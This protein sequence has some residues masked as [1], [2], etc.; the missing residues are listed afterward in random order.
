MKNLLKALLLALF[1]AAFG[2]TE[3]YA[4]EQAGNDP[5]TIV[6]YADYQCP[7]CGYYHNFVQK[8][9][10]E[11]GDKI[12]VE[13]RFFPLANHRYGA[14]TARAAQ[15]AKNQGKFEEM[16]NLLFQNQKEWSSS[17]NAQQH[18]LSY[19]KQL[20]LDMEQFKQDLNSGETQQTVMEEKKEG[21]NKGVRATPTFFVEGQQIDRLPRSYEDFK[22]IIQGF[23]DEQQ[24]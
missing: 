22:S 11:M 18:I 2:V 9:E 13:K 15:S 20:D 12:E 10:Q 14:L 16:H 23:L 17:G 8:L 7:A 3:S 4:Q 19:A 24:N 6:E 1:I 21:V 5:L